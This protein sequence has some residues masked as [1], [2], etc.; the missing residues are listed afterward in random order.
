MNVSFMIRG[1]C[2][3]SFVALATQ[4]QAA[5]FDYSLTIDMSEQPE[6][7]ERQTFLSL[8]EEIGRAHV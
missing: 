5:A 2:V 1:L 7:A 6:S 8:M 3:V 4:A